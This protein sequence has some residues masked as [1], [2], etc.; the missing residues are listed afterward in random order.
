MKKFTII[1][2]AALIA[3]CASPKP[4]LEVSAG[5]KVRASHQGL[6][7]LGRNPTARF[8][9]G[10]EGKKTHCAY[11]HQSHYFSGSPFNSDPEWW[12]ESIECGVKFGGQ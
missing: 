1:F 2:L 8:E 12:L 7:D 9:L 5:Y 10:I 3:G 4:Y 11:V 6:L